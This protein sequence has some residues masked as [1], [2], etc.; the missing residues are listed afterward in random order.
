MLRKIKKRTHSFYP[1]DVEVSI[2]IFT[3]QY[4]R[5]VIYRSLRAEIAKILREL[6]LRNV[7][8]IIEAYAIPDHIHMGVSLSPNKKLFL[9][10]D[11]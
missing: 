7:V 4:H 1:Y 6:C 3:P 8:E 5:K 11:I 2:Y 9:F 10:W